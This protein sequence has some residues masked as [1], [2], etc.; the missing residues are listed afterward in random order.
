MPAIAKVTATL[1]TTPELLSAQS[2]IPEHYNVREF[3]NNSE[4]GTVFIAYVIPP[5]ATWVTETS[6]HERLLPGER[7][8]LL[9]TGDLELVSDSAATLQIVYRAGVGG[10]HG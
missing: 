9:D 8:T 2:G 3:A 6:W 7:M 10:Y 4:V 1:T 5:Y